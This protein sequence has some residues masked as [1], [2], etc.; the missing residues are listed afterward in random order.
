MDEVYLFPTT[1]R[2]FDDYYAVRSDPTDVY[3]NGFTSPPEKESFRQGF[4]NRTADARF[5]EPEDRRNY[6]IKTKDDNL[7][8]GF[9][10]LIRRE[11]YIDLGYSVLQSFQGRGYATLALMQGINLALQFSD[12]ICLRIRDD[13][14]ASQRVAAKCGFIP[15]EKYICRTYPVVGN[16]KLRKYI[17]SR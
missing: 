4:L 10:Q 3:W 16:V 5:S 15:T 2:D 12:T 8:V 17:L 13:N 1:E 9:I 14:Y 11:G 6:L 7:T